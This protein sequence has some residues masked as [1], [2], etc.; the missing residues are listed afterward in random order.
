[1]S[2]LPR[3]RVRVRPSCDDEDGC[4]CPG[5]SPFAHPLFVA[6][7]T[8]AAQVVGEVLVKRLTEEP[9]EAPAAKGRGK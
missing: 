5:A 4:D 9:A 6:V 7:A 3:V 8:V 2:I 1:M